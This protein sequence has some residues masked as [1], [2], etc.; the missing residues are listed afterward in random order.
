MKKLIRILFFIALVSL[1][2]CATQQKASSDL[3]SKAFVSLYDYQLFDQ[4]FKPVDLHSLTQEVAQSDV[5]FIGE[6]HGN[7]ASHLLQ[8]QLLSGIHQ[9]AKQDNRS[10]ILSM[11]MFERDQQDSLDDY[12]YSVVGERYLMNEV[13]AWPNYQ[14]SYR[15]LVEYAKK[16]DIPVIAANAPAHI[17]RCIGSLGAQHTEQLDQ[18]QRAWIAQQ[19]FLD[20][21]DYRTKFYE[22]M[23]SNKRIT[24]EQK[25]RSYLAQ[26]ARDNT[27]AE[28]ISHAFIDHSNAL[29][30]H[31]NGSFH[32]EER[33]GTA[34]LLA[35]MQPDLNIKIITPMRVDESQFPPKDRD[36]K[37]DFYYR[38]QP[39]PDE[40]V[41][42][43]YKRQ[44]RQKMFEKA[45]QKAEKQCRP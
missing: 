4:Q 5:V 36:S 10:V 24:E 31:L 43:D 39:Q 26:L 42:P 45:G 19:P 20:L 7:H 40:F 37:D 28:S 18:E 17:V 35:Q 21:P 12:L 2:G 33:L 11:E 14:G 13:P 3:Q 1:T 38:V 23:D 8:M 25:E 15:P 16:H 27:M 44:Y 22:F 9:L 41:D 34:G 30:V 32:S 29:V 6:Y